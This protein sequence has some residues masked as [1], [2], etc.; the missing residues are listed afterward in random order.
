MPCPRRLPFRPAKVA[1]CGLKP[2]LLL[3]APAP[4]ASPRRAGS[5]TPA[6]RACWSK[7]DTASAAAPT[8]V[9]HGGHGVDLGCGWLHSAETNPFVAIA[10]AQGRAIDRSTPAWGRPALEHD[11]PLAEQRAYQQAM[12]SFYERLSAL[13][14]EDDDVPVRRGLRAGRPLERPHRRGRDLHQRREPPTASRRSDFEN[15]A[16]TDVNWRVA[17]GYGTVIA[18]HADG[19]RSRARNAGH[20][21][22]P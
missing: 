20:A 4:P 8:R 9:K 10:E 12:A 17:E 14:H 18:A 13:A 19:C 6:C 2:K 22:R 5:R 15:Y 11:F 16:G 7:R 21:H 3:S 1:S